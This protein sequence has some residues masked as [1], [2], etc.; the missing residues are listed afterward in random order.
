MHFINANL[1]SFVFIYRF[2]AGIFKV[3]GMKMVSILEVNIIMKLYRP[4]EGHRL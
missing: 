3:L 2:E 1:L 4:K